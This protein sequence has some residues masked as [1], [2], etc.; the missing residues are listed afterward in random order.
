MRARKRGSIEGIKEVLKRYRVRERRKWRRRMIDKKKSK[1]Q[2]DNWERE[3]NEIN[4]EKELRMLGQSLK[5]KQRQK[6]K[7]ARLERRSTIKNKR[8]N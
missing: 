1:G 3:S 2:V 4:L 6:P 7:K 8:T 5:K